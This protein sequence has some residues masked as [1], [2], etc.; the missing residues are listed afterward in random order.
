M[1]NYILMSVYTLFIISNLLLL[2]KSENSMPI[3]L[4]TWIFPFHFLG[5]VIVL[6]VLHYIKR[7]YS[8]ARSSIPLYTK[9]LSIVIVV[10]VIFE[11]VVFQA[12]LA[13]DSN[14]ALKNVKLS[15]LRYTIDYKF[16]NKRSML[17][18][19]EIYRYH[20]SMFNYTHVTSMTKNDLCVFVGRKVF[21][22]RF[23]E[24]LLRNL[25]WETEKF[26]RDDVPTSDISTLQIIGCS[27]GKL[28]LLRPDFIAND[29]REAEIFLKQNKYKH[30]LLV[31]ETNS[32]SSQHVSSTALT[33]TKP[34]IRVESFSMNHL[35]LRISNP[36]TEDVWLYYADAWHPNWK[37]YING[38]LVHIDRAN[39]AFKA[40]RLPTG[41]SSITFKFESPIIVMCFT[42]IMGI[43]VI[44]SSAFIFIFLRELGR[45][46]E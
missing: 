4:H 37:A 9:H 28:R 10:L 39:I 44:A 12:Y 41:T 14:S 30:N 24:P 17:F 22:N 7:Y 46:I 23:T 20:G 32:D 21:L 43:C 45:D 34:S 40:I 2:V 36:V 3:D 11:A 29:S 33:S 5:V 42:I 27:P 25:G 15:R 35:N 8:P 19:E 13:Y 31:L 1:Y 26:S 18:P 6:G 38:N 16:Q